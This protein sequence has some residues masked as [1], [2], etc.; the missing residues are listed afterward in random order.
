MSLG[1]GCAKRMLRL[2]AVVAEGLVHTNPMR[3][4]A[5][6]VAAGASGFMISQGWQPLLS[7]SLTVEH[8]GKERALLA[9]TAA[10]VL[11]EHI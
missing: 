6:V 11:S 3:E 8:A 1:R 2:L 7:L 10:A 9:L 4:L 5:V